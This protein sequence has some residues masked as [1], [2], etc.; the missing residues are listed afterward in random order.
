M[1]LLKNIF[2][3][4]MLWISATAAIL[5]TLVSSPQISDINFHT[6]FSLLAM[7]ILVQVL[8]N[9]GLLQYISTNLTSKAKNTRQLMLALVLLAFFSAMFVTNDVTILIIAPLFFKIAKKVPLSRTLT[10][11]LITIAANLGSAFTPFGNTH[12]LFLLSHYNLSPLSFFKMTTP[13]TF[14]GIVLLLIITLILTKS[15]PIEVKIVPLEINYK[16]IMATL[17]LTI[18]IFLG[19]FKVVPTFSAVIIALLFACWLKPQI[20][21]Q[22]DYATILVFICFF[23]AVG[24]ISRS[25]W[26]A[27]TINRLVAQEHSTYLTSLGLS[28]FI[29]NVPSTILIAKFTHHIYPILLGSNIGGLGTIIA[30]M[31]NLLSYK[32]YVFFTNKKGALRFLEISFALNVVLLAI[33]GTIGFLLV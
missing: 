16:K 10:I 20:L 31:A 4:K 17:I 26:I 29:S 33:L 7:M 3:D 11:V 13:I 28:Q 1:A 9:V 27:D 21:Q 22:V 30:S 8:E 24:N 5:S 15:K 18:Y 2:T 14:I 23:I 19:I 25:P 32:Q 12:N 6:I